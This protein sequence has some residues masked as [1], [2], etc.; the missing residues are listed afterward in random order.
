MPV[1]I[2]SALELKYLNSKCLSWSIENNRT[3]KVVL[4]A[5]NFHLSSLRARVVLFV[6][7]CVCLLVVLGFHDNPAES[8]A[9]VH[10]K[11]R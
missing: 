8:T 1:D 6:L 3:L 9:V 10:H 5:Q 2:P 11:P 4:V 7:F